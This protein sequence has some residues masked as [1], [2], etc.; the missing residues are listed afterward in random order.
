MQ[1]LRE[2]SQRFEDLTGQRFDRLEV[3]SYAGRRPSDLRPFWWCRCDC[4]EDKL[5][6]AKMLKEGL[7]QSCG[8]KSK[9]QSRRNGLTRK[10]KFR[11]LPKAGERFGRLI[12]VRLSY[13]KGKR[14]YMLCR[15]DCGKETTVRTDCLKDG[16]TRSCGCLSAEATGNRAR[17]HGLSHTREYIAAK[18][19]QRM[20]RKR[21]LDVEW[22]PEMEVALAKLQ[23]DC[24]LCGQAAEATD[25]V[26]PLSHGYGLKPGN[27]V[28]LCQS[29]NS[30]KGPKLL[31][32]LAPTDR[33]SLVKAAQDFE[34]HWAARN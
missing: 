16:N 33:D 12:V 11:R 4:G 32:T 27:A 29:C 19:K 2:K 13:A 7:V 18:A 20:E 15:C 25:H 9:E 22:T 24:V 21:G 10:G 8:C 1:L 23:P 14:P 3:V 17:T 28:R 6:M 30:S 5:A 26:N 31:T 34:E